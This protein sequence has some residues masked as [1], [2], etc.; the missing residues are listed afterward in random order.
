MDQ[1]TLNLLDSMY[2]KDSYGIS[3]TFNGEQIYWIN[4]QAQTLEQIE[5]NLF[6]YG[7]F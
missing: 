5:S 7:H 2:S 1:Q 6:W 4:G 3:H